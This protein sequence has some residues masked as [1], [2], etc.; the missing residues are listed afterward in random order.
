MYY[1]KY[2]FFENLVQD[3]LF[4]P[5]CINFLIQNYTF[6]ENGGKGLRERVEHRKGGSEGE[7]RI[8]P[9]GERRI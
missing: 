7:R 3:L 5:V 4:I 2:T 1:H 6:S 9:D 8:S